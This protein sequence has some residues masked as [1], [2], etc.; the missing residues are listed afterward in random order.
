MGEVHRGVRGFVRDES[1][2]P[3]EG[4]T[5]KIKDR[6]LGFKTTRHGEYWRVLLPGRYVIEAFGDGYEPLEEE[7][8]VSPHAPTQV[9]LTLTKGTVSPSLAFL[10]YKQV[11]LT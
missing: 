7:F 10:S 3:L 5:L 11:T 4:V 8:I 9:N 6:E 2:N 1:G